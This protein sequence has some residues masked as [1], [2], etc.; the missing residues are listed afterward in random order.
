MGYYSERVAK[1]LRGRLSGIQRERMDAMDTLVRHN[2]PMDIV[3]DEEDIVK[4]SDDEE[5]KHIAS[6]GQHYARKHG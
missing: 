2:I 4:F 6:L 3:V 1:A 5:F